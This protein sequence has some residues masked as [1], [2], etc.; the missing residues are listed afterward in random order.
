MARLLRTLLNLQSRR[1]ALKISCFNGLRIVSKANFHRSLPGHRQNAAR[2]FALA[3]RAGL[4]SSWLRCVRIART[5]IIHQWLSKAPRE[6]QT[7]VHGHGASGNSS[8]AEDGQHHESACRL[9][10]TMLSSWPR[11]PQRATQQHS[12]KIFRLGMF[13]QL[14]HVM[15]QPRTTSG[16]WVECGSCRNSQFGHCRSE[17]TQSE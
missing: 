3:I 9:S 16:D 6:Q 5:S 4:H 10:T 15:N 2:C 7:T 8:R 11:A 17:P 14:Q 1:H 12:C 13:Q